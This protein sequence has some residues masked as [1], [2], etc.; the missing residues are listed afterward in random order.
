LFEFT[1]GPF[2]FQNFLLRVFCAWICLLFPPTFSFGGITR[3]HLSLFKMVES[4]LNTKHSVFAFIS[5]AALT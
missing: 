1:F 5:V 3:V 2:H 4:F